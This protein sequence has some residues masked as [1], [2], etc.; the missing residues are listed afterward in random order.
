M[1]ALYLAHDAMGHMRLHPGGCVCFCLARCVV[2]HTRD[3]VCVCLVW[4]K[5]VGV[6]LFGL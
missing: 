5:F 3:C 4:L 2:G 1:Y 6:F